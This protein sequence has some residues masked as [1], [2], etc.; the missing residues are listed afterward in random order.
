MPTHSSIAS[1]DS[2]EPGKLPTHYAPAERSSPEDLRRQL[3]YIARDP[4]IDVL[5]RAIGGLVAV[6]NEHRQVL[7]LNDRLL[8]LLGVGEAGEALGLRLGE[9]VNCVHAHEAP[10]GCGTTEYCST[11]GAAIAQVASLA[12]DRPVERICAIHIDPPIAGSEHLHFRVQASPIRRDQHRILLLFMQDISEEQQRA[13]LDRTFFH[14]VKNTLCALIGTSEMLAQDGGHSDPQLAEAVVQMVRGLSR[15][16]ELQRCLVTS[17]LSEFQ[18]LATPV[19]PEAL[20]DELTRACS[21]HPAAEGKR[22]RLIPLRGSVEVVRVDVT[23]L[24]RILQNMTINALEATATGGE[25][26]VWAEA[27][28]HAIEFRVWNDAVIPPEIARRV[29]Q[30]NF[31]TKADLGRGLGTYSM[32]LIGERVLGGRVGFTSREGEGTCFCFRLPIGEA[33]SADG[34]ASRPRQ[35]R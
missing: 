7:V 16:I 17:K 1:A 26:K 4:V 27:E 2:G 33:D 12:Q 34:A 29:F 9:A 22:L 25:V 15:E 18:R 11:C 6:L 23:L 20:L 24:L 3:D 13:L 28:D 21:H 32:K 5:M 14:D 30:R 8:R 19:A 31:S 10:G 35:T